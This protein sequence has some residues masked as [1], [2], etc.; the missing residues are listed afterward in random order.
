MTLSATI[1]L[2]A[3]TALLTAAMASLHRRY[4]KVRYWWFLG[5]SIVFLCL[6]SSSLREAVRGHQFLDWVLAPLCGAFGAA[7]TAV[8]LRGLYRPSPRASPRDGLSALRRPLMLLGLGVGAGI[9]WAIWLVDVYVA[10]VLEIV[11]RWP[12]IVGDLIDVVLGFVVAA[13]LSWPIVRD[14][15]LD[16]SVTA[17]PRPDRRRAG[18]ILAGSLVMAAAISLLVVRVSDRFWL[19][20]HGPFF[21]SPT[22]IEWVT[23]VLIVAAVLL[24]AGITLVIRRDGDAPAG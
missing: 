17:L 2:T 23:R 4:P 15:R 12:T 7:V 5:I 10:R 19:G 21:D 6:A 8:N 14:Q 11:A 3:I 1:L 16:E 9:P 13:G 18:L 20:A 22:L 24:A